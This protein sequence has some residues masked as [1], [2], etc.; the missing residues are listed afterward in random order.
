MDKIIVGIADLAIVRYPV[1]LVTIGLGSCVG[2]SFLDPVA[3]V[4]ALAHIVLPSIEM[5]RNRNVPLKFAD[6]GIEIAVQNML[7]MG[8]LKSRIQAKL[9]GGAHM[10]SFNENMNI[11]EKNVEAVTKKLD[12]M[13]IPILAMDTGG[14]YGR[15]IEFHVE[16]GVMVVKS[17]FRG[18]REI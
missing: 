10:F 12:E 8:C 14:N 3:K 5:S 4:G 6:S 2:I 13:K 16:T 1:V 11:G 9:A 18:V 15:T 7:K 17:A